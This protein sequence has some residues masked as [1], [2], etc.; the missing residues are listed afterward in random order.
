MK[1]LSEII[2]S[3]DPNASLDRAWTI[4]ASWY[5]DERIYELE[6]RTAFAGSWQ[7]FCR[8]DQVD[9]AGKFVTSEIAK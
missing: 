7:Q 6:L 3:Y 1:P 2:D 5:T 8:L 4:P 9:E